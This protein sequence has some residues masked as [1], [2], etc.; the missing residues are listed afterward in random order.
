MAAEQFPTEDEAA[1][2]IKQML[3]AEAEEVAP[4]PL[5]TE[6]TDEDDLEGERF[7]SELFGTAEPE[8]SEPVIEGRAPASKPVSDYT[9]Q[10]VA[11]SEEALKRALAKRQEQERFGD[12][13]WSDAQPG[14]KRARHAE[15]LRRVHGG[16]ET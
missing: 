2:A 15:F 10:E 1:D 3:G 7:L 6:P 5:P 8:G 11:A 13:V 9:P 4:E 12:A 16:D 14:A